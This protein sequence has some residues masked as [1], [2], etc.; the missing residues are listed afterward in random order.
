MLAVVTL[1]V[2]VPLREIPVRA[3]LK[4]T[5]DTCAYAGACANVLVRTGTSVGVGGWVGGRVGGRACVIVH[6]R[7]RVSAYKLH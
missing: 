5:H 1:W 2:D 7:V 4:P 3:S 6:A